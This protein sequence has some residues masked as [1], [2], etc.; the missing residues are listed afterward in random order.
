M[1]QINF[2]LVLHFHQPVGNF[3][4]IID[5][6]CQFC[7]RPFFETLAKYPDI[8]AN[9][10]ISGC[11]FDY[12]EKKHSDI[13][14]LIQ[15]MVSEGRVEI[16]GGVYYESILTAIPGHDIKGQIDLMREKIL[17]KFNF[18]IQG[19]WIPERVWSPEL[20]NPIHDAG[21]DYIILDDIH[22]L[23]AGIARDDINN[24]FFTGTG[25]EKIAVFPSNKNLRYMIPFKLSDDILNYFRSESA[26]KNNVLF[27]Y[28]DDG[29]KFGEWPGT[30]KWVF[31]E[32][33]LDNFF[34]MLEEN[35]HW[36]RT[37]KL[38]DYL[39]DTNNGP[40]AT[41]TIPQGS[42]EEMMDWSGGNWLNFLKKYPESEHMRKKMLYVSKKI[43]SIKEVQGKED[44]RKA[45]ISL[46]KGQCNC[47]YWHGVFG[48]LY[49]YHLRKAIYDNLIKADN[50]LDVILHP[51]DKNWINIDEI[52]LDSAGNKEIVMENKNFSIYFDPTDGGVI[53][54]IDYK[55][56]SLNLIN[57]LSRKKEFYHKKIIDAK[58]EKQAGVHTIH[59][60]NKIVENGVEDKLIY[61]KFPRYCLR[62][63]LFTDNL[64]LKDAI[65]S[66]IKE[67][68]NF[69][70][71]AYNA[72]KAKQ[73]ITLSANA[74]ILG[75]ECT[76]HKKVE[77]SDSS[78]IVICYIIEK[79]K[80]AIPFQELNLAVEFNITAPY[81]NSD[82]YSYACYDKKIAD[83][84]SSGQ[85]ENCRSF[86][87]KDSTEEF[88]FTLDFSQA[89]TDILYFPVETVS[90][91]ERAYELHYQCSCILPKW[92]VDLSDKDR[93]EL[94]INWKIN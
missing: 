19:M 21:I 6:A 71:K 32:K 23:R 14:S 39:K 83:V 18:K 65:T 52:N 48:G 35:K 7:Y 4:N 79:Q 37:I 56:L 1:N 40:K 69:S 55:P 78:T 89:T 51:N 82:R 41:V 11:L 10:H 22:L 85:I 57:T 47:A 94:K 70:N 88:N 42:Y 60:D 75:T 68:D 15:K 86:G 53:K 66:S 30:H 3:E 80:G 64:S 20:V 24:Y 81:L 8:K 92:K 26:T 49:L 44:T 93:W 31:E 59:E 38:S 36:I 43:K 54:E 34:K 87:I 28:G 50:E 13:I 90:Q 29:E 74:E 25:T 77:F 12:L 76:I 16:V 9:I 33:W 58:N 84:N 91:S 17:Q 5:R 61:D 62:N 45:M 63:Y 73:G 67:L 46:Y 27:T 2:A 72:S